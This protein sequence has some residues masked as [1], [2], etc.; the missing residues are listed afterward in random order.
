[1]L[2]SARGWTVQY[3]KARCPFCP[4]F[5]V[6]LHYVYQHPYLYPPASLSLSCTPHFGD[7][8]ESREIEITA[9]MIDTAG[10]VPLAASAKLAGLG[11]FGDMY[12][13]TTSY[14]S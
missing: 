9:L 5:A 4:N 12:T 8:V 3:A 6:S 2:A 10:I 14:M 1:M 11:G 7:K 13:N